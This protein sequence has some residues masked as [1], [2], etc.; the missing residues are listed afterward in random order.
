[1]DEQVDAISSLSEL[2]D[3]ISVLVKKAQMKVALIY[4][5]IDQDDKALAAYQEIANS[6][7]QNNYWSF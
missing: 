5:N 7:Y 2:S 3:Y 4:R 6:S 1:M